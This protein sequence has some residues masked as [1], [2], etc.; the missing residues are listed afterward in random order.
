MINLLGDVIQSF[1]AAALI[2]FIIE[3]ILSKKIGYIYNERLTADSKN[4][5]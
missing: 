5:M 4:V 3:T 1:L 2:C